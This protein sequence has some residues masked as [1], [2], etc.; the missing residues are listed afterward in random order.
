MPLPLP[1][2]GRRVSHATLSIRKTRLR[3]TETT[4]GSGIG[5]PPLAFLMSPLRRCLLTP[6]Y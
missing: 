3:L 5:L 6:D 1:Q 4:K 2:G